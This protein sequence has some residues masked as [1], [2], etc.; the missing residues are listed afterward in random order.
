MLGNF[1]AES[2]S[3]KVM[4]KLSRRIKY[5]KKSKIPTCENIIID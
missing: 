2:D 1:R 3:F 4:T 5:V